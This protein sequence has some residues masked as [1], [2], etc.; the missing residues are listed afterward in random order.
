MSLG[1]KVTAV[2]AAAHKDLVLGLGAARVVDY[3]T[4]DFA[5]DTE[6]YDL[7]L[8]AVGKG[9][10]GRCRRL[11]RHGIYV[12]TD[13]GRTPSWP[14]SPPCSAAGGSCSRFRPGA[15][16]PRSCATSWT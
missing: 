15:T 2:C 9:S 11:L 16:R 7:V 14:W 8:D 5:R 3:T 12:S 4:E 1:A 13:L 10:F 6:T